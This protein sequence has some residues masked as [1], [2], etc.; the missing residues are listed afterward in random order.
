[1]ILRRDSER[2]LLTREQIPD[3]PPELVDATSVFNPGACSLENGRPM[4]LLRVQTRG[5]RTL[6]MRAYGCDRRG[7]GCEV[8]PRLV[9]VAGLDRAGGEVFHV[10]DPRITRCAG[11]WYVLCALDLERGCRVGIFTTEDF[12]RLELLGVTGNRDARNGV[13]FPEKIRGQFVL[14]ERPNTVR[15]EGGAPTGDVIELRRSE[16]LAHW[17]TVGPVLRGRPHYWDELIGAGP[18][19]L[20]TEHGW[21]LIYH[22]VATHLGGGIYQAG[23]ALLDL[24]DP[25]RVLGRTRD[26]ILEP[27]L[28]WEMIGQ[29][30]N[31]VFPTGTIQE[32]PREDGT[33][34]PE[35][36]ICVIYGA[37]DSC[38]GVASATIA[39]LVAACRDGA[40]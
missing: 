23:A 22:G 8:E 39:D 10:Y 7:H 5:R 26:N 16:D 36:R 1:M 11:R 30:P 38:V 28:D 20:K 12:T 35:C 40:A 9:Q 14:L 18:P 33:Y 13:L 27:R 6:F 31:V 4:L 34:S 24:D 37:A 25:T 19:P 29:V 15:P 21:L 32:P 2:P 3:V 17:T